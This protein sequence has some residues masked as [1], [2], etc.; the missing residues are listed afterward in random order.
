[1][2]AMG[3]LSVSIQPGLQLQSS[4]FASCSGHR[5]TFSTLSNSEDITI[6]SL[7]R[8]LENYQIQL[9]WNSYKLTSF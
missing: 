4:V 8:L 3:F 2:D 7:V 5:V 9:N 1:M 6:P